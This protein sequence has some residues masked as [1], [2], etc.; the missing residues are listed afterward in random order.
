MLHNTTT[1]TANVVVNWGT[2]SATGG[3]A[4][5][6][7]PFASQEWTNYQTIYREYRIV[8]LKI[9]V[10]PICNVT[11]ATGSGTFNI[12]TGSDPCTI[13]SGAYSDATL[14]N[15]CDY[16][17]H[18][19]ARPVFKYVGLSKFFAKRGYKWLPCT[20]SYNDAS[21]LIRMYSTGYANNSQVGV[22][23]AIWYFKFKSPF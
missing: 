23:E 20:Q 4:N 3:L 6:L 9:K 16:K 15:L 12:L 2:N 22:V 8:G 19:T 17:E 13:M 7:Q 11:G 21:T 10:F 14:K 1:G 18:H 5:Q